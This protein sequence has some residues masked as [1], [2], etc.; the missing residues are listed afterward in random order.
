MAGRPDEAS[1]VA[2]EGFGQ[3]QA[4]PFDPSLAWLGVHVIRSQADAIERLGP[5]PATED[6]R[7][8]LEARIGLVKELAPAPITS[9]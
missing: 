8:T 5:G 2:E 4:G 3:L 6:R 9:E 7:A 1:T